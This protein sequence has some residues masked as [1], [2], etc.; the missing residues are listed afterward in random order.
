MKSLTQTRAWR[1]LVEHKALMAD[2]HMRDMF[3]ADADRFD[4]FS[5]H[6]GDL[7]LDYSK[8]RIS[9][10]T[11]RLLVELATDCGL[12]D[13]RNA[14]M[15]G[16][17]INFTENR[18]VL[19]TALRRPVDQPLVVGGNDVMSDIATVLDQMESFTERVR[20]GTWRGYSGNMI[21]DIVNIGIGGSDLGP[22]M[23][24]QA[25]TPYA[26]NDLRV[27][28]ISNV[29]GSHI[30]QTLQ[31]L[32]P[33]STLF[34]IASKTF[35][36]L[37]TITNAHT[38]RRWFLDHSSD[39]SAITHHFVAVSTDMEKV[40]EF[41]I[42]TRN[43][44]VFRDWVGGRYS[45]W[46]AIGLPIALA[47]GMSHFRE[48]LV[49]ARTMD[50]H[51]LT[52][53]LHQ[54]MPVI[55]ALLGI[56]YQNFFSAGSHLIAPYDQNMG[57]FAAHLQQL[58]MESNGKEVNQDGEK[59]RDYDTGSIIWGEPGCNCQHSFFQLLH[60]GTRLIPTDF[61]VAATSHNPIGDHHT[62]LL[63][64]TFAQS[65]ALMRGRNETETIA[66]MARAGIDETTIRKLLPHCVFEGNR[67]SNTILYEKLTP[68]TLGS[69]IALYEHKVFV[70]GV[71]WGINSFDQWGVELGK[72]LAKIIKTELDENSTQGDHDTS[73]QG[74]IQMYRK[75]SGKTGT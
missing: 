31:K 42:D 44:F 30:C 13:R 37:E 64:S 26:R 16:E 8:N 32:D 20:D 68:A 18:A 6:A 56:W 75:I 4:R 10:D 45:L 1:A 55:L 47:V 65:E 2:T 59:I 63:A 35:T 39:E 34:I 12:E 74:L 41:G 73:T 46:S 11:M 66:E 70:Q 50:Q 25:L 57:R 71:I 21:T 72:K 14:M 27:H 28:F 15:R 67:P 29:D 61:L 58:D 24:C 69:L 43:M 62:N 19:H 53:P 52:A 48:L 60:Q 17:H 23:V 5:L 22:A 7:F 9:A 51:F 36:T 3:A 54:N 49:G 38:A 40:R 33:E